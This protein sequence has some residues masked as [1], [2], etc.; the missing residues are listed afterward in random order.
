[1]HL[2]SGRVE[3]PCS[4]AADLAAYLDFYTLTQADY[5]RTSPGRN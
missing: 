4:I 5:V 3:Y 1:M 2:P